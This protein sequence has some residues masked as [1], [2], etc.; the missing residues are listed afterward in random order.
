[1]KKIKELLAKM[2]KQNKKHD[3]SVEFNSEGVVI[4]EDSRARAWASRYHKQARK[5]MRDKG[6][7]DNQIIEMTSKYVYQQLARS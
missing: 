2:K 4:K 6:M 1:M 5:L 7:D 3:D